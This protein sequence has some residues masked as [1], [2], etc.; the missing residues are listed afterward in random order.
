MYG[1]SDRAR[2]LLGRPT[3][4]Q[5]ALRPCLGDKAGRQLLKGRGLSYG[6][7]I[8]RAATANMTPV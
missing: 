5:L 3:P 6:H 4:T 1:L 7:L 8:G 2:H